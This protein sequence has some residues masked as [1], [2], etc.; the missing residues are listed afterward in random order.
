MTGVSGNDPQNKLHQQETHQGN[1]GQ[2]GWEY[3]DFQNAPDFSVLSKGIIKR[4][5]GWNI[6]LHEADTSSHQPLP[7]EAAV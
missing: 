3:S 5:S 1:H 6:C 4:R 2:Q 7:E